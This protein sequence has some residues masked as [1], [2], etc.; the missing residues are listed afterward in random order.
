MVFF[1][2]GALAPD[3]IALLILA[4][5]GFALAALFIFG[6]FK[7]ENLS[8]RELCGL[9]ILERATVP[10]IVENLI[11]LNCFTE[12]ICITP[13]K[14][15]FKKI[16]SSGKS[17]CK[18]F[19]GEKNV[20]D[21]EVVVDNN[22]VHQKET[23][24]IIQREVAN[25]MFDCWKMTGTGK[26]D[27]WTTAGTDVSEEI[28]EGALEKID[29]MALKIQPRCIICSRI[30][31]SDD[32]YKENKLI[33]E[34]ILKK[35]DYNAFMSKEK[36]PGS[37]LTYLQSFTDESVGTGYS[38]IPREDNENLPNSL[39]KPKGSSQ[40]AVVFT[41]IKVP[42]VK[43]EDQF[44][45]TFKSGVIM[46]GLTAISGPGKIASYLAP[47]PGWFKAVFKVVSIGAVST[48]LAYNA[49]ATTIKNQALSAV[50]CGNFESKIS[51]G[52]QKGCSLV[53]LMNW[54]VAE[55]NDLCVGG[56]EGNP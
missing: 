19:A 38:T 53:K 20:R 28:I 5:V 33:D 36:V 25:V 12:K 24:E 27:I 34:A 13:K 21:V 16:G 56:I 23:A 52:E 18:Q 48:V 6:V 54:D 15:L 31:I 3:Q 8:E 50:T 45:R 2:R 35:I 26:L 32:F 4:I 1:K 39:D 55:I 42:N 17:A 9:S 22:P 29:L 46:G 37:S 41:Q 7:N 44:W 10:G 47:G 49:E 43:P 51:G 14:G 40:I 11:P 30:A